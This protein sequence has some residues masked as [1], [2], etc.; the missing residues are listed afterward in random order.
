MSISAGAAALREMLSVLQQY[1]VDGRHEGLSVVGGEE[2]SLNAGPFP[3]RN[4][5]E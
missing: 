5:E 1:S 2:W 4:F 3:M